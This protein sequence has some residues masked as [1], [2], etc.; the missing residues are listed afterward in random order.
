MCFAEEAEKP[1]CTAKIE[2]QF[3]P[4]EANA[5]R[6]AARLLYQQGKLEVCSFVSWRYKWQRVSVNVRDLAKKKPPATSRSGGQTEAL[7]HFAG[8]SLVLSA[9]SSSGTSPN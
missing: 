2:G 8:C 3:W 9:G 7:C 4:D 5:D 6:E 1:P